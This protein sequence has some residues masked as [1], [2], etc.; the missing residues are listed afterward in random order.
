MENLHFQY[1][2]VEDIQRNNY[3]KQFFDYPILSPQ[4]FKT[5]FGIS[6]I[7]F[8]NTSEDSKLV[9]SW[10]RLY[11][12]TTS[13]EFFDFTSIIRLSQDRKPLLSISVICSTESH[14]NIRAFKIS[15]VVKFY[16]NNYSKDFRFSKRLPHSRKAETLVWHIQKIHLHSLSC[17]L[18]NSHLY[19]PGDLARLL[20][21]S[22]RGFLEKIIALLC[23]FFQVVVNSFFF[24][25]WISLLRCR[26]ELPNL[27]LSQKSC[28]ALPNPLIELDFG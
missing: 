11:D 16:R 24:I 3:T 4:N 21:Q 23:W 20:L 6:I 7:C 1:N 10:T 26:E 12:E 19:L 8:S 25:F 13:L 22:L 9:Q 2:I 27:I 15:A 14:E 28:I 5:L 18:Y 17:F